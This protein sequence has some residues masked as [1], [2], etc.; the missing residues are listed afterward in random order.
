[1]GVIRAKDGGALPRFNLQPESET[2][3]DSPQLQIKPLHDASRRR[4][5][6]F[7]IS[8]AELLRASRLMMNNCFTQADMNEAAAAADAC[9]YC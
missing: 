3:K 8:V 4:A 2:P 9:A 7:A 5:F 1:L 6:Q